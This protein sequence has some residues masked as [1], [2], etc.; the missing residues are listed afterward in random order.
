MAVLRAQR[1]PG[2]HSRKSIDNKVSNLPSITN[3]SKDNETHVVV[4][5]VWAE[6]EVY[7]QGIIRYI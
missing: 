3:G 1:F 4:A 2:I 6:H 5:G 7:H